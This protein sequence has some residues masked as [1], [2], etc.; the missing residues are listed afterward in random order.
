MHAKANLESVAGGLLTVCAKELGLHTVCAKELR[1]D[2][3][4]RTTLNP[5]Q[6]RVFCKV[7]G[8]HRQA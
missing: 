2:S 4:L 7:S 6:F 3:G 5:K 8:L 1:G